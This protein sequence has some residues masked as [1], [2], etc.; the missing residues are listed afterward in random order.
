[1]GYHYT[2][3]GTE[4]KGATVDK[5][6]GQNIR[7]GIGRLFS[8]DAHEEEVIRIAELA[9]DEG[10]IEGSEFTDCVIKGPAVLVLQGKSSLANNDFEGEIDAILWE[11]PSKRHHVIGAVLVKDST[12]EGCTFMN[13]GVA[14]SPTFI[15]R[16][17][18]N[19]EAGRTER[20]EAVS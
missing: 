8:G 14:G 13:V 1:V 17:R 6:Y 12:F 2:S 10:V 4:Q 3:S 16:L 19:L 5:E 15:R 9:G 7:R 18:K 20:T 11:I